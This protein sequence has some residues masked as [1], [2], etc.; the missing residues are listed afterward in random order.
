M[1]LLR[2]RSLLSRSSGSLA[3]CDRNVLPEDTQTERTG[4]AI[5]SIFSIK[6]TTATGADNCDPPL[7]FFI[8]HERER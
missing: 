8:E 6:T 3:P 2:H 7:S 4:T 5:I 1:F